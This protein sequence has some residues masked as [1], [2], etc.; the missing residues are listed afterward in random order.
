MKNL[1]KRLWA[2]ITWPFRMV[3]AFFRWIGKGFRNFRAFFTEVPEEVSL[4]DTVSEALSGRDGFWGI[5]AG[6]GEHIDAMRIHLLR[7]VIA[8]AITTGISFLFAQTFMEWLARPLGS[9][10]QL[11]V[12][13]PTESIGVYMRVSLL[14][15]LALAM[16][17]IV[18]EIYLFVAPGLMPRSRIALLIAIPAISILFILGLAFTYFV[19]LPA[20]IGFLYSFGNF[21]AA[22]RPSAYF[23]LVTSLMFWVGVSF[24]MPM[25]IYALAS[26]GL[27]KAKQLATQWKVAIVVITVIAAIITPTVDP[28]NQALVMAP[29]IALYGLSIVGA[30]V[31]ERARGRSIAQR[32]AG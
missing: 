23:G 20:A 2:G 16:P 22:W 21:K 26:I 31:A 25:V 7:A 14:A 24:Q 3:A 8:L 1:L 9:L 5:I 30:A 12:I 18:M 32:A 10:T 29:M 11:Q 27:L 19:M 4:T 17:W 13:E 28:V 15:G 6:L